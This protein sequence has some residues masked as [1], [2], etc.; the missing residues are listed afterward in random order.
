MRTRTASALVLVAA[1]VGVGHAEPAP[2]GRWPVA[3]ADAAAPMLARLVG[4]RASWRDGQLAIDDIAGDGRPWIGVVET[5]GA[6]PWLVGDGFALR[7]TGPLARPR[8][9]G[10]GYLVWIIGR[11]DRDRLQVRRLGVLARPS[12]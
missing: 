5:R 2:T 7:L 10:V 6:A 4:Q 11:R 1:L 9:A 8:I 3:T 12:G